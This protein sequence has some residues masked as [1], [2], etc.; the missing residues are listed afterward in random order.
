MLEVATGVGALFGIVADERGADADE[1]NS[2]SSGCFATQRLPFER[3][4]GKV[5]ASVCSPGGFY[6]KLLS[7]WDL[8]A[9]PLLTCSSRTHPFG[10]ALGRYSISGIP[11]SSTT[12]RS[13]LNKL[14]RSP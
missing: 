1:P 2:G 5:L 14:M 13:V 4:V 7:T 9:L 10:R 11:C 8:N 6:P 12:N 3:F